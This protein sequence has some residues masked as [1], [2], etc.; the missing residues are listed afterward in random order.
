MNSAE[1]IK[2][3]RTKAGMSKQELAAEVGATISSIYNW[4]S[5]KTSPSADM[6]LAIARATGYDLIFQPKP[7]MY[8][9][10]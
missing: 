3:M 9:G 1:I 2:K 4:E 5:G 6:L 10:D 8:G 7:F